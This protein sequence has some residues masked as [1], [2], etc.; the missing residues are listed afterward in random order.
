MTHRARPDTSDNQKEKAPTPTSPD[1]L[2]GR[3]TLRLDEVAAAL[4]I[5]RRA[6]ERERA[7][8]RFPSPDLVI[9]KMPLWKPETIRLWI[10]KGGQS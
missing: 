6:L 10:A 5:S 2:A 7:A 1:G 9:G 3:L 8:G 4:G